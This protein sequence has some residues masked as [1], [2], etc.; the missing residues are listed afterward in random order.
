[1]A[2]EELKIR[3]RV[4]EATIS[5]GTGKLKLYGAYPKFRT[6]ADA[7]GYS[8]DKFPY[9]IETEQGD[10]EIGV[11]TYDLVYNELH[12]EEIH[13]TSNGNNS[14]INIQEGIHKVSHTI[15]AT[16]LELMFTRLVNIESRVN[17][18]ENS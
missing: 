17:A 2:I 12:R 9:L 14:P 10:W 3:D 18:L 4:Q 7:F 6:F 15:N 13:I 16:L 1:M 8:Y 5:T 11:G